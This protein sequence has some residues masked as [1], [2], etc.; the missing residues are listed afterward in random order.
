MK[1]LNILITINMM[2]SE[3]GKT[4]C[5]EVWAQKSPNMAGIL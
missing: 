3:I 2:R 5:S 4:F 1:K